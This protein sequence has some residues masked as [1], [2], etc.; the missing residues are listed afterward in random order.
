MCCGGCGNIWNGREWR[1]R[2]EDVERMCPALWSL[3]SICYAD[4]RMFCWSLIV[5]IYPAIC[6]SF[7]ELFLYQCS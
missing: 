5:K 7:G 4:F 1:G 2:V 3:L 6:R